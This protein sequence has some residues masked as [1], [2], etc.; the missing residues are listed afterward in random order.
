MYSIFY[1]SIDVVVE[2]IAF[3][4]YILI[5]FEF[6]SFQKTSCI[7]ERFHDFG[8]IGMEDDEYDVVKEGKQGI[9][10]GN[11]AG[12]FVGAEVE[13]KVLEIFEWEDKEEY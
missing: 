3:L 13:V 7:I 11:I 5:D 8:F 1:G 9:N 6:A 2:G 4:L 12:D 10:P